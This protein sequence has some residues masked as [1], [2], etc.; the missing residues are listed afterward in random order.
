V[1]FSEAT[2]T[3]INP[4]IQTGAE[5]LL[6]WTSSSPAG[7]TF[8]VYV[9]SDLV[10]SGTGLSTTIGAPSGTTRINIGTVGP[11][12]ARINFADMLPAGPASK[13][14]LA[15]LGGTFEDPD[16]AGFYVFGSL[17]PGGP[18]DYASPYATIPAYPGGIITD[19]Y[20]YGGFGQGG[21]GMAAGQYSWESAPLDSGTWPWAVV[22]FDMAGNQGP[23][24]TASTTIMIPPNEP[25]AFSDRTRL[26][27]TYSA[28]THEAVLTW[29]ASPP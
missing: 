2:I 23:P 14:E 4:P 8:Q 18:I 22:P 7:T 1:S 15:W 17:S 25:A 27:Y 3:S 10:W 9:G 12:E 24:T 28:S 19:G 29:N 6:S 11:G 26:H 13:A 5:L 21:F 16:I 20:G